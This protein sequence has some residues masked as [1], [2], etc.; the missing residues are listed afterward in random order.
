MNSSLKR[1]D[2]LKVHNSRA[3]MMAILN[4]SLIFE[5]IIMNLFTSLFKAVASKIYLILQ[6]M[7]YIEGT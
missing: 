6:L 2:T 7:N 1:K 4:I 5:F 3:P